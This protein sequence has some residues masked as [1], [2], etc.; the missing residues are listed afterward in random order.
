MNVRIAPLTVLTALLA[1]TMP[2]LAQ[3]A[4]KQP[5]IRIVPKTFKVQVSEHDSGNVNIPYAQRFSADCKLN[6]RAIGMGIISTKHHVASASFGPF[7]SVGYIVGTRAATTTNRL[8]V[9]CARNTKV[10]MRRSTRATL[11]WGMGTATAK[12]RCPTGYVA[13]GQA[14]PQEFTPGF[15]AVSATPTGNPRDWKAVVG[16]LSSDLLGQFKAQNWEPVYA[17]V[18]CAKVSKR[19]VVKREFQLDA[20]GKAKG[21]VNCPGGRRALGYGLELA[22]WRYRVPNNGGWITPVVQRAQFAQ[23]RVSFTFGLPVGATPEAQTEGTKVTAH[24]IC[25]QLR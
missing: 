18:A 17:D 12:V 5:G 2:T 10:Q 3:A 23:S 20:S 22:P 7:V 4:K 25:G 16:G 21:P 11:H 19:K 14:F 13:L 1:L 6:E 15:G 24:V 8:Q 9:L